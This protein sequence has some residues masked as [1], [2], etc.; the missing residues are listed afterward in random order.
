M[1]NAV[2]TEK[3]EIYLSSI[4][5]TADVTMHIDNEGNWEFLSVEYQDENGT[6][7]VAH[8]PTTQD[9]LTAEE[10]RKINKFVEQLE[11][12]WEDD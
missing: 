9:L 7:F 3:F 1:Y 5:A 6:E 11:P 2:H 8:A 10:E 12:E 4:E